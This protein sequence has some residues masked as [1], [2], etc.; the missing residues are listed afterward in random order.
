MVKCTDLGSCSAG[1]NRQEGHNGG[2][3]PEG[4]GVTVGRRVLP[5]RVLSFPKRGREHDEK[6][7]KSTNKTNG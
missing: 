4:G 1:I 2:V 5:V 6:G 7:R 3:Q